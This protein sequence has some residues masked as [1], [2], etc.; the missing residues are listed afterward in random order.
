MINE[1]LGDWRWLTV[2][3]VLTVLFGITALA[4]PHVTL[5]ALLVLWAMFVFIDGVFSLST[6][7]F[8]NLRKNRGWWLFRGLAGVTI[9]VVTLLWPSVTALA[10]LIVITIWAFVTGMAQI[11]IALILRRAVRYGWVLGALGAI[12]IILSLLLAANPRAGA[13]VLAWII[14]WYALIFGMMLLTLAWVAHQE[15]MTPK[16]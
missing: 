7:I 10:L 11:M 15:T 2:R 1:I 16:I 13:V 9:G 14:G 6:V 8:G 5:W 12:S 4:W 3:G